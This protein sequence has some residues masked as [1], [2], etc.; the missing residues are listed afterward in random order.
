MENR[1]KYTYRKAIYDFLEAHVG[2]KL[3]ERNGFAFRVC[4]IGARLPRWMTS[5]GNREA[6]LKVIERLREK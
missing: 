4:S 6:V 3:R 1:R 5:A 2:A